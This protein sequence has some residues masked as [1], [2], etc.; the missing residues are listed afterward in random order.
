MKK[1]LNIIGTAIV[2]WG[3]AIFIVGWIIIAITLCIMTENYC[4]ENGWKEG[5]V[6]FNFKRYC[7]SKINQT[8]VVVPISK[9]YNRLKV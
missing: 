9:A 1:I 4:V 8:D 2:T 7:S 5:I 6:L 3:I